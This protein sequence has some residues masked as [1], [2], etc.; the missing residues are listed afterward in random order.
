M[1]DGSQAG[2]AAGSAAGIE[3]LAC[4]LARAGLHERLRRDVRLAEFT[5]YRVGGPVALLVTAKSVADVEL[6]AHE[7]ASP[8]ARRGE[9]P[10]P[11][12]VVGRGSNL[13]V[14]DSGF[15]GVALHLSGELCAHHF[16]K[17]SACNSA[18][19]GPNA[20]ASGSPT[21]PDRGGHEAWLLRAGGGC[22]LPVLARASVA[23]GLSGF[24]WA[25]GVP[26]TLGGAVRMNAG[27][28]GSDMAAV[29]VDATVVDLHRCGAQAVSAGDLD[30]GYRHSN[31]TPSQ[32][33]VGATLALRPHK[34][35]GAQGELDEIVA[36]RRAN[37]PGGR[38]S[39]SVFTNPAGDTAGR[40]I[41]A[42]GA[43]GL[44]VGGA[45]ISTKHAN[46]IQ[47]E[48]GARAADIVALMAE[49][50]ARVWHKFG[51][52]LQAET[53]LVGFTS[54]ELAGLQ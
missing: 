47:A 23:E 39:G 46:F 31:I 52:R 53:R 26:G 16:E 21:R 28:H 30:L 19:A 2:T 25:V 48:Q 8:A 15:A 32:V 9:P 45:V 33:V 12:L 44:R 37:Q 1:T 24:E 17:P 43:K 18:E 6:L 7:I 14:S 35:A 20:S 13:L 29:L 54:H 11:V 27:G 22:L 42:A 50:R 3:D 51:V 4:R 41:D 36:W 40:L 38:N 5:T 34:S 49:V 10:T